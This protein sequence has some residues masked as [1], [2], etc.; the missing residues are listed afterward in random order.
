M[1]DDLNFISLLTKI[2]KL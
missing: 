2:Q 1:I